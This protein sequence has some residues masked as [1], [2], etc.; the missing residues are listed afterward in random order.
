MLDSSGNRSTGSKRSSRTSGPQLR[1]TNPR[2]AYSPADGGS[3]SRRRSVER[4]SEV[5]GSILSAATASGRRSM[6][7]GPAKQR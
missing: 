4:T 1:A 5:S 2:S 6:Q 3:L 7:R